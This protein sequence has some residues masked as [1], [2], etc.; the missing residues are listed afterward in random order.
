MIIPIIQG[1]T[2]QVI[3]WFIIPINYRYIPHKPSILDLST[4]LANYGA[5]PCM[6]IPII[7]TVVRIWNGVM[8]WNKY[9]VGQLPNGG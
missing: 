9:F 5:P 3:S 8:L 4:K 1:G 7:A 2:P 6:I